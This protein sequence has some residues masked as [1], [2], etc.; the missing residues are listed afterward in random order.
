MKALEGLS[1]PWIEA[2]RKKPRLSSDADLV[3]LDIRIRN[4]SCVEDD[5]NNMP[6]IRNRN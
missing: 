1:H 3:I 2:P 4:M 5:E 6:E